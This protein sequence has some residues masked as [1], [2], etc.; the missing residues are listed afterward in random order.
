M[1]DIDL[2]TASTLSRLTEVADDD[3]H[4]HWRERADG[5][6]IEPCVWQSQKEFRIV[7]YP[8]A[9]GACC[10]PGREV[11]AIEQSQFGDAVA[12]YLKFL[13]IYIFFKF[14]MLITCE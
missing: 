4:L 6:G 7:F 14:R 8:V 3:W 9:E 11:W 12:V 13:H 5:L 10:I 2:K 1:A